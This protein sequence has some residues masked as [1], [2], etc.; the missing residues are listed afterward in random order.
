MW[1]V[2]N[3]SVIMHNLII[4]SKCNTPADDGHAFDFLGPFAEV[5]QVPA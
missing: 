2:M 5:E 4:E 3:G 1:E